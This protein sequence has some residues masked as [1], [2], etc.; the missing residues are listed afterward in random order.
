MKTITI[1][2]VTCILSLVLPTN[3]T[4][5][6]IQWTVIKSSGDTL[7]SCVI[8]DLD[9]NVVYLVFG[10]DA[11]KICVDSL[12]MLIKHND[13]HFWRGAGYG[14]PAGVIVGALVGVIAAAPPFT[15]SWSTD[16][17]KSV[18]G[19]TS[20]FEGGFYGGVA[21]F[22]VGGVIGALSGGEEKHDLSQETTEEKIKILRD[23]SKERR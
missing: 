1:F 4:A 21:G 16:N 12:R 22:V 17:G 2:L 3:S 18:Y 10:N 14:A 19:G 15:L 6:K 9:S 8:G 11:I 20:I 23:L 7:R 13:S 5:Q